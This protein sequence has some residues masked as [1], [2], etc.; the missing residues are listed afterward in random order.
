MIEIG[1]QSI[2][3]HRGKD[4]LRQESSVDASTIGGEHMVMW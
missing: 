2:Y 3:K 1:K 4:W